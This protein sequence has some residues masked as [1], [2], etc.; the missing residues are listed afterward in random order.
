VVDF[1]PW[2]L[3][4]RYPLGGW[5]SLRSGLDAVAKREKSLP[6]P[7]IEPIWEERYLIEKL[8]VL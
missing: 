8:Q 2:P 1:T 4:P 7:G 6:L 5:L 3:Y